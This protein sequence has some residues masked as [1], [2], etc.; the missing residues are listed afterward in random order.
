MRRLGSSAGVHAVDLCGQLIAP[1]EPGPRGQRDT[2]GS[3]IGGEI[4]RVG[5]TM[6]LRG[7]PDAIIGAGLCEMVAAAGS[8]TAFLFDEA[9]EDVACRVDDRQVGDAVANGDGTGA[10]A[11]FSGGG[12]DERPFCCRLS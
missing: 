1:T 11:W 6:L 3:I 7:V 10:G 5:Q 12:F 9:R 4:R 2:V 8:G